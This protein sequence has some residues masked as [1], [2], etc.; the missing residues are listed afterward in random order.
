M[1][2][3]G[4]SHACSIFIASRVSVIGTLLM[5]TAC[6]QLVQPVAETIG[7]G[8]LDYGDDRTSNRWTYDHLLPP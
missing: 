8:F 7:L 5:T 3:N 1:P 6:Q 2:S 4:A